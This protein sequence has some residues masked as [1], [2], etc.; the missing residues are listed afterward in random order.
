MARAFGAVLYRVSLT[1][2]LPS[3]R[4][5]TT[6]E[7]VG[8]LGAKLT[9][10]PSSGERNFQG[11]RR[12]WT[13][14]PVCMGRRS[15]KIAGRKDA[16]NLKKMKR[17]S[18]IGKEIVAAIQK[19]GPNPTSNTV[20][21]A[22]LE[23][24][25]ELEVPK[26]IVERNIKKASEK[27]QEAYIEKFYEVYGF[28]GVGMVVEVLTDKVTRSVAAVRGVAK[29]CGAK[30]ADPGSILFKFRRAQ[31]INIKANAA[32]KDQLLSIALDA[33][34]EDVIEPPEYEDDSEEDRPDS[35][36]KIVTSSENYSS[37]LSKLRDEGIGFEPDNG[38]EL[39]PFNPIEVDDEAMDL[40]KDL[41]SKLLELDDV[42]AVY[43]D[44]K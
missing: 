36:Y 13:S 5:Q 43:S 14:R 38:F 12:I 40:N 29:D 42:D 3:F 4:R 23:K 33:G 8:F 37:I 34:A 10:M 18:K 25:R 30:L 32:D 16:Q 7:R 1:R 9:I 19:G 21:A 17:N 26:E 22:V 31:V 24:A 20:L 15:C 6:L 27:G 11:V 39:L 41:I 35:Y 2:V 44:Q 28:G